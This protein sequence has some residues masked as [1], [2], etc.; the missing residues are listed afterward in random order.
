VDVTLVDNKGQT[1]NMGS[2]IDELSP[3]SHPDY[4]AASTNSVEQQYHAHR[5]L[6]WKVM[7]AAG[8]QRHPGEWWHFCL[9]DQMW[10][11]LTNQTNPANPV[12]ARYGRLA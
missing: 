7:R 11:W 6:L 3:R 4:F 10:A 9:G 12:V 5:Q 8:F 2:A 1:V